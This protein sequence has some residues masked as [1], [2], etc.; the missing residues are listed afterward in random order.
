MIIFKFQLLYSILFKFIII[1]DN[2]NII[3]KILNM[4]I[5][6]QPNIINIKLKI[7]LFSAIYFAIINNSS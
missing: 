5:L 3:N 6:I 7:I 2:G 1:I 4:K